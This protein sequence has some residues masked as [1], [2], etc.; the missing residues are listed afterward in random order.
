MVTNQEYTMTYIEDW[1][2]GQM[3][4]YFW[5]LTDWGG[6][7]TN[8]FCFLAGLAIA[9]EPEAAYLA[10]AVL[11]LPSGVHDAEELHQDCN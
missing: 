2:P 11:A 7:N 8:G 5:C 3:F 10:V 1:S 6:N 9:F 4:N